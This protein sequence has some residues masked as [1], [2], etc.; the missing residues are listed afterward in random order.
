MRIPVLR[1][2]F[3]FL[4]PGAVL[5]AAY[6]FSSCF[7]ML[8]PYVRENAAYAPWL[9]F[10]AGLFLSSHFNRSR[11]FFVLLMLVLTCWGMDRFPSQRLFGAICLLLPVNM[12]IFCFMREKGILT[13]SGR[14]RIGFIA[15]QTAAIAFYLKMGP[16]TLHA[17]V[18][19][20]HGRNVVAPLLST[21]FPALPAA[22]MGLLLTGARALVRQTPVESGIFGALAA[23]AFAF[24]MIA[25]P[26]MPPV[27]AAAAGLIVTLS[28]LRD[29]YNMAFRDELTGLASRRALNEEMAGFGRRYVVAM[30]DVDHFKKVNDTH[31]HDVGDQVLK[32]VAGRIKS[33][34][35]EGKTYRYGGE[36]FTVVFT[37]KSAE[38]VIPRL[39]NLRRTI[40]DY[41]L[42][43]R[44]DD[45]PAASRKGKKLRTGRSGRSYVS[46]TVS[47]GVAERND[48]LRTPDDV[49][50]AADHAL[51]RAKNKGRNRICS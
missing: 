14:M 7:S 12:T 4:S 49:L 47:M 25:D 18:I 33:V 23:V 2:L 44:A 28:V 9:I 37:R 6:F 24:T 36:E 22:G 11:P 43:L 38:E 26:L 19:F 15:L 3:V 16:S 27:F 35:P 41:R 21:P 30:L 8:P 50:K 39:E 20:E 46:V 13:G 31:G 51:Y 42:W 17:A 5:L 34:I 29:S 40:A 1:K 45:R 32:M 48:E 10:T